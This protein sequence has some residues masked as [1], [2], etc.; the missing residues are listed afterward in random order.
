VS[1]VFRTGQTIYTVVCDDDDTPVILMAEYVGRN[2][3]WHTLRN[4][5]TGRTWKI[6]GTYGYHP[7]PEAALRWRVETQA[8]VLIDPAWQDMCGL[9]HDRDLMRLVRCAARLDR[10]LSKGTRQ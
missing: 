1:D 2:R 9:T 6:N 10:I 5:K 8:R 7:S 3:S 4:P